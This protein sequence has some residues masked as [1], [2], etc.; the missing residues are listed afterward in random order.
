MIKASLFEISFGVSTLW[1]SRR[2]HRPRAVTLLMILL[3]LPSCF[4]TVHPRPV[5][6]F[7]EKLVQVRKI[8]LLLEGP[9]LECKYIGTERYFFHPEC[10]DKAGNELIDALRAQLDLLGYETVLAQPEAGRELVETGT[11]SPG[12]LASISESIILDDLDYSRR[13]LPPGTCSIRLP[14]V[15]RN[16]DADALLY[17]RAMSKVETRRG[18]IKRWTRNLFIRKFV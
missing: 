8:V 11:D 17:V 10:S 16:V 6:D 14:E 7:D 15:I 2:R 4:S 1:L 5:V 12:Q 9:R 3:Y 13:E 18:E